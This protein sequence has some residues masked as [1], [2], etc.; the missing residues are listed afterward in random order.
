MRIGGEDSHRQLG[1]QENDDR[2][3]QG[4]TGQTLPTVEA[5]AQ[6]EGKDDEEQQVKDKTQSQTQKPIDGPASQ[7]EIAEQED[8]SCLLQ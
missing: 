8:K 7:D 5:I 6:P 2:Q 4:T 3:V 1:G